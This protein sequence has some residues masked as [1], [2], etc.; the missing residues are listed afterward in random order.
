MASE[1]PGPLDPERF[2]AG[3]D[4]MLPRR[5]PCRGVPRRGDR[6]RHRGRLDPAR[7]GRAGD[8]CPTALGCGEERS[9]RRRGAIARGAYRRLPT[10][11]PRTRA[12][13][14]SSAGATP[15]A[16][17]SG[18]TSP[19]DT[20]TLEIFGELPRASLGP[21]GRN[22]SRASAPDAAGSAG[23]RSLSTRLAAGGRLHRPRAPGRAFRWNGRSF[24]GFRR[25]HARL[26][27]AR[28]RRDA[29]RAVASSTTARAAS[30]R[31]ASRSRTPSSASAPAAASSPTP[32]PPPPTLPTAWT[33]AARTTGRASSSTSA[34]L[35]ARARAAAA[36]RLL[37]QDLHRARA[38]PGS[39]SSS[40]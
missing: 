10:T 29:G 23:S 36:G 39:T 5:C 40:R 2:C 33:P 27:A 32:A 30:S 11:A 35:D 21:A 16:A 15:M 3:E 31:A 20:A 25:R 14:I 34:P 26:G 13:C 18:S 38:P 24:T 1:T 22:R 28:Q 9:P 12:A 17:A 37:L 4:L 19:R 8:A 6:V 7:T